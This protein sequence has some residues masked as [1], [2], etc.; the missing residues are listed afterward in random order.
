MRPL[1]LV[2]DV[3][4]ASCWLDVQWFL[5]LMDV[6]MIRNEPLMLFD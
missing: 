1:K 6:S 2:L 5:L 3:I 4:A